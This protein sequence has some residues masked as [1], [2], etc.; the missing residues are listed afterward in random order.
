M[1]NV[2]YVYY[3]T[4]NDTGEV[5]YVGKGK[6]NRL[7]R[8]QNRSTFWHNIVNKAG[9]F[10]ST[11]LAS[12]L[13]EKESLNFEKLIILKLRETGVKI[14]NLTDGGD[15]VSGY[16]RS[17]ESRLAQSERM[18]GISPFPKGHK[19]SEEHKEKLRIAQTGRKHT[20]EHIAKCVA[21][22][23]GTPCSEETRL[24]ISKAVSGFKHSEETRLK[25]SKSVICVETG[26][27]YPS[28]TQAAISING[29]TGAISKC[30]KGVLK[31]SGGFTWQYIS[32]PNESQG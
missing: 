28:I 4:R 24:K 7:N 12:S 14:C 25:M 20:P 15:G 9:G 2:C 19:L 30:C 17:D 18:K 26:V 13:T 11:I 6:N 5:F 16:K 8:K 3:H 27:I 22:R 21:K 31:K 32:Q 23:L 1:D 29:H 10:K